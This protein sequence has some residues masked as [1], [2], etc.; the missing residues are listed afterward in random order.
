MRRANIELLLNQIVAA[1]SHSWIAW[2]ILVVD[3]E[4]SDGTPDVVKRIAE[5]EPRVRLLV[6]AG[7]RGLAGLFNPHFAPGEHACRILAAVLPCRT[8]AISMYLSL[9]AA[10]V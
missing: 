5:S 2:E 7:Q 6:R 10:S 8:V 9:T 1:L 3:D 4:S